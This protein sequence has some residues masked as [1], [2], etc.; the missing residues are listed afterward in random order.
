MR[1]V[2][3]IFRKQQRY[4]K[5][6]YSKKQWEIEQKE[7][8]SRLFIE[9]KRF[10]APNCK[11]FWLQKKSGVVYIS[12]V[13][14]HLWNKKLFLQHLLV[15]VVFA[16]KWFN[17]KIYPSQSRVLDIKQALTMSNKNNNHFFVSAQQ[18]VVLTKSSSDILNWL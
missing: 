8:N 16:A 14:H 7:N 15:F 13:Y 18:V 1:F 6:S 3:C 9:M 17:I 10:S 11:L 5:V 4:L 2:K 12:I